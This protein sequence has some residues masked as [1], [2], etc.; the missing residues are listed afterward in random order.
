MK[1]CVIKDVRGGLTTG[2]IT[3]GENADSLIEQALKTEYEGCFL[4]EDDV[5]ILTEEE[6]QLR[7]E[8][9]PKPLQPP[10]TDERLEATEAAIL[11]LMEVLG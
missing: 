4:T 5:V 11:V 1:Y 9:Q 2:V 7:L 8:N 3:Q 10:T 6:Y